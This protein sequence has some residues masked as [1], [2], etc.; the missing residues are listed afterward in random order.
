MIFFLPLLLTPVFL[1]E[2]LVAFTFCGVRKKLLFFAFAS[3]SILGMF[4]LS[5][6]AQPNRAVWS[7]ATGFV[8]HSS[9]RPRAL[10]PQTMVVRVKAT[11]LNP[12]D[13]KLLNHLP[14]IPFA[15]WLLHQSPAVDIA[16]VVVDS[17]CPG[18]FSVG[19]HVFGNG[20]GGT[21]EFAVMLCF[22]AGKIPQGVDYTKA[23]ASAIVMWT[24]Q[25]AFRDL[26]LGKSNSSVV[27]L[28]ASGGCGLAGIALA[29]HRRVKD[30]VCV[31]SPKNH[32]LVLESGCT[33]VYDYQS[34]TFLGDITK[35]WEGKVDVVYDTVSAF[36]NNPYFPTLIK[37]IRAGT[38]Q[39][40]GVETLF[41]KYLEGGA[42]YGKFEKVFAVAAKQDIEEMEANAALFDIK[43]ASVTEA[44][45]A[46]NVNVAFKQLETQRT[47]GKI[48][49][50]I[51]DQ[52][53][54]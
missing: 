41:A 7:T 21:Q 50:T 47:V 52:T 39:Y 51:G 31:S 30:I 25:D 9:L 43:L 26:P 49:L 2:L 18:Q 11:A 53:R 14:N 6:N 19:D 27:I 23:A 4:V 32:A 24:A 54:L 10:F 34:S 20:L 36:N 38:G 44:L 16:G 29:K 28:G 13:Y 45:N 46:L 40:K 22:R 33:Q 5:F 37:L 15:R 1:I 17:N 8:L 12:V 42:L 3:L 35:Q 48:V